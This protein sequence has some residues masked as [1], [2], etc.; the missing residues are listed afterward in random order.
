MKNIEI[1]LVSLEELELDQECN[2]EQKKREEYYSS[3]RTEMTVKYEEILNAMV[4]ELAEL[5]TILD[6]NLTK[7][8]VILNASSIA[9]AKKS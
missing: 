4:K 9:G 3:I 7:Q 1:F 2:N 6:A 5:D 8:P